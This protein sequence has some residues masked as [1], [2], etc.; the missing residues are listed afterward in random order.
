MTIPTRALAAGAVC[1]FL[2]LLDVAAGAQA[3]A[4]PRRPTQVPDSGAESPA[5]TPLDD[6]TGVRNLD[7]ATNRSIEGL[8]F[9][10]RDDGTI[11]LDL[12]GRFQNVMLAT[13]GPDGRVQT[14][15]VNDGHTHGF[16]SLPLWTPNRRVS[17]RRLVA[18]THLAAPIVVAPAARPA[19][20]EK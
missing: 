17:T 16:G 12:Q 3:P 15:C 14:S 6:G 18:P 8:T 4:Q 1:A 11:G 19:L 7:A 5:Q 9:E 2:V 20:E 13:I 10:Y